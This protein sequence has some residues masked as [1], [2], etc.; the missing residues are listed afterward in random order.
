VDIDGSNIFHNPDN[1]DETNDKNGIF[2]LGTNGHIKGDRSW[3]ETEVAFVIGNED[4]MHDLWI[5]A[6]NSLTLA[7]DVVIK[8]KGEGVNYQGSNIHGHDKAGVWFTSYYDDGKKGDTNGDGQV[9]AP[10]QGDWKGI[11]NGEAVEFEAWSN[12]LYSKN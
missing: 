6:E 12:I 1:P 4:D 11:Y 3:S 10:S 7:S 8:L 9:T 5:K 2:M